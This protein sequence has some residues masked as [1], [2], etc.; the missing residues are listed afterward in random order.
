ML[1][2]TSL[3]ERIED[4]DTEL[5]GELEQLIAPFFQEQSLKLQ[6]EE[7]LTCDLYKVGDECFISLPLFFNANCDNLSEIPVLGFD[8]L[9]G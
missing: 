7:L 1:K 5:Q 8:I 6:N 2:G 3:S 9:L 4:M